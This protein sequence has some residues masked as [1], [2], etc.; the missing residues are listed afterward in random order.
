MA[1]RKANYGP[2]INKPF[3]VYLAALHSVL[4]EFHLYRKHDKV[5]LLLG[6]GGVSTH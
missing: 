1:L 4:L 3:A 5:D 6:T 2:Q